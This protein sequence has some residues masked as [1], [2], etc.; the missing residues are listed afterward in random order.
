MLSSGRS[1]AIVQAVTAPMSRW[2]QQKRVLA[3]FAAITFC[4]LLTL[5]SIAHS[6]SIFVTGDARFYLGIASGDYSQVMQPF[7]SRQ[8]GA[9]I[10]AALAHLFHWTIER[11]F[12]VEGGVSIVVMLVS[13]CYL[14]LQTKA[15][16]WILFAIAIVPFWAFLLQD[17]VLPDLWYSALL[18]VMFLLL[19]GEHMLA[20]S[21]MMFPL[22]LSRESTSLT[23]ICLLIAAWGY[24]RWRDRIVALLS[25]I[26]GSLLV[27]HLAV[28]AQPNMEH[29]PQSIYMLAKVP[30]NFMRNI[31]GIVPWSNVN[32]EF[33][34]VPAW[35]MPI[36]FGSVR[37]VGICGFS[38][39]I[40]IPIVQG[41]LT[42]F[43]LL[44]ML[45]AWL[46]WRRRKLDVRNVL[47]RFTLLYGSVSLILAPVL[48]TWFVRLFG[49]C[50]P[51][52][53]V[54]LPLLFDGLSETPTEG[55][56]AVSSIGFFCT[57][58]LLLYVS[59]RWLWLPQIGLDLSL[60]VI[61]FL[62]L[63]HWL[64]ELSTSKTDLR[65]TSRNQNCV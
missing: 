62:L 10:V 28:R 18:A 22:M 48:G 59:Y 51:I 17:L 23:L 9:L 58:L 24:M 21:L 19:A 46:W 57:H 2:S 12:L 6:E 43:G 4:L 40:W 61:G 34:T 55:S 14:A 56:R 39:D 11:G 25:A 16:R 8:L 32:P 36:H 30:W 60:W 37:T 26:G 41:T 47:L 33:C 64:G 5:Y 13:V 50:W 52:F 65:R 63:R 31:L 45:V 20:A 7:A 35:S 54:S 15:P 29:L 49:Y 53:F 1:S 3:A 42:N 38:A 44:P 27:K